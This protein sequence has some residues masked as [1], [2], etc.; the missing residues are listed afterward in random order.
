MVSRSS[1]RCGVQQ[2]LGGGDHAGGP[3][4][5]SRISSALAAA[6]R[7]TVPS[8]SRCT[9]PTFTITPTSGSAIGHQLGDLALRRA[10]PSRAPAPPCRAAPRGWSAAARSPCSGSARLAWVR[11]WAARS[12]VRMSLVEVL[13]VEPV[14]PT[15]LAPSSRRQPRASACSAASGSSAAITTP[16]AQAARRA[17]VRRARRRLRRPAPRAAKRPPSARWPRRPTNRSPGWTSR[18]STTARPR[19]PAAGSPATSR[20]PAAAAIQSARRPFTRATSAPRAPPGR[21]RRA[22]CAR[23]RTPGPARGPCRR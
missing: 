14:T 1:R 22:P 6:T 3:G 11:R 8:S 21:R 4:L 10:W 18:V 7:S 9:G 16:P 17:R 15:T 5:R 19:S 23:P 12:A 13:P 20:P 2:R